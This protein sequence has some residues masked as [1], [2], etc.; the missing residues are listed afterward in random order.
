MHPGKG[1]A[2][3]EHDQQQRKPQKKSGSPT[4]LPVT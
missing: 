1:V 2:D 4:P 3:A